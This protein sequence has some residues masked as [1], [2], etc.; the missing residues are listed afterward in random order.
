V[1]RGAGRG[2]RHLHGAA[3]GECSPRLLSNTVLYISL[4][5]VYTKCTW[6]DDVSVHIQVSG[7]QPRRGRPGVMSLRYDGAIVGT[8]CETQPRRRSH[9][10][11]PLDI[12][13]RESRR[14]NI[15]RTGLVYKKFRVASRPVPSVKPVSTCMLVPASA[16]QS[17]LPHCSQRAKRMSLQTSP[18]SDTIILTE[19]ND[20]KISMYIPKEWQLPTPV[21]DSVE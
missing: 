11:A 10:H 8:E 4:V 16:Y 9:F 7:E 1:S 21:N 18:R 12:F 14:G 13:Y 17:V 20:S 3:C 19:H 6:Q 5:I 2:G 15:H